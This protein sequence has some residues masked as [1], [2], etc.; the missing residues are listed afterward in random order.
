MNG[1]ESKIHT[2]YSKFKKHTHKL[3]QIQA[4]ITCYKQMVFFY[5]C[6]YSFSLFIVLFSFFVCVCYVFKANSK[7]NIKAEN[8]RIETQF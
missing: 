6:S 4:N 1:N 5:L 7:A 2:N 8:W 3:T